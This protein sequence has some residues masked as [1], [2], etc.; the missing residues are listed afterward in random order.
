MLSGLP[1]DETLEAISI[2]EMVNINGWGRFPKH[3]YFLCWWTVLQ[4]LSKF[5]S[6]GGGRG[7]RPL[8]RRKAVSGHTGRPCQARRARC[9]HAGREASKL[10]HLHTRVR[11]QVRPHF[12]S[13]TGELFCAPLGKEN[14]CAAQRRFR[15]FG[16]FSDGPRAPNP[17]S[18]RAPRSS[19]GKIKVVEILEKHPE[20]ALH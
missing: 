2:E 3:P 6:C 15:K 4:T 5:A 11:T 7:Q 18:G 8:P 17:R 14:F 13:R 20:P 12:F 19:T 10:G 1:V 9:G 16:V